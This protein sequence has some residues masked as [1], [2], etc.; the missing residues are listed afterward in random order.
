MSIEKVK[1][2]GPARDIPLGKIRQPVAAAPEDPDFEKAAEWRIKLPAN[3]DL[4]RNPMLR[5]HYVGDVA[6]GERDGVWTWGRERAEGEAHLLFA[7]VSR[8]GIWRVYRRVYAE[9]EPAF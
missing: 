9:A 4:G 8:H 5:L 3:L 7:K 2:A 1:E 6:R